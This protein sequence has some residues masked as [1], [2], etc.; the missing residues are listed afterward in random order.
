MRNDAIIDAIMCMLTEYKKAGSK[1]D[2]RSLRYLLLQSIRQYDIPLARRYVSKAAF[3]RWNDLTTQRI[4][5]CHYRDKVICDKLKSPKS[6]DLYNGAHRN[7]VPTLLKNNSSFFFR[8]MFHE[9]HV[10]PVS[11]ILDN[12]LNM[13]ILNKSSIKVVLE[14]MYFCVLL[15]EEDRKIPRTKGRRPDFKSNV[16]LVYKPAG[17]TLNPKNFSMI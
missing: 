9:D 16:S 15:K 11:L 4:T 7:S 6:Y 12:L 3:N 10:I 2:K 13:H 1:D 14:G 5:Q 17:I 8:E